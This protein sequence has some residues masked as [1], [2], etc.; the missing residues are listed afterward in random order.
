MKR[1]L[2]LMLSVAA[3]VIAT[4]GST[5]LGEAA[6]DV[7]SQVVPPNSVGTVQ[8]KNNSV[9]TQQLKRSAVTSNKVKNGSLLAIDFASGQLPKGDKGDKGEKGDR[10]DRGPS[11][12]TNAVIRVKA[13]SGGQ[14]ESVDCASGEVATGGGFYGGGTPTISRPTPGV[15]DSGARPTGWQ[16]FFSPTTG[17]GWIYAICV[18]P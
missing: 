6:R 11:G 10:G 13:W 8:L 16:A 15:T 2:P 17:Q 1:R 18:S 12:A 4:L 14:G 3:L 5:P 7:V 9:G